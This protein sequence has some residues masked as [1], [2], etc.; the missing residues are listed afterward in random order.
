MTREQKKNAYVLFAAFVPAII[1]VITIIYTASGQSRTIGFNTERI[2]GNRYYMECQFKE[3]KEDNKSQFDE[4][5]AHLIR[6][7]AK[8]K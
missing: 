3:I 2:R 4:L 6:I 8:L 1:F 7:E 5:K